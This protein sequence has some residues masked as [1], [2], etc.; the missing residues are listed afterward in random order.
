[1]EQVIANLL[2][3]AIQYN[4]EN[5]EIRLRTQ[6]EGEFTVLY[7]EDTGI[8]IAETDLPHVFDRFYRAD[9]A[10]HREEGHAGLGLAICKA[11]VD[12]GEGSIQIQSAIACGTTVT[13]R[14]PAVD[15]SGR[16][17]SQTH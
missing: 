17:T 2:M 14:F 9:R 3:N 11:I 1:M 4:N 7:V 10:R 13:V 12:S 6:Q 16:S 8:G 15:L 5:G